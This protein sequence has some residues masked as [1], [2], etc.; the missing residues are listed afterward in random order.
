MISKIT[1]PLKLGLASS[2]EAFAGKTEQDT[3]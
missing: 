3:L 2:E 1:R